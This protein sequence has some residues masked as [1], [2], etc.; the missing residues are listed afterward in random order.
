MPNNVGKQIIASGDQEYWK[1]MTDDL[2]T[3]IELLGRIRPS[4]SGQIA[5]SHPSFA[6]VFNLSSEFKKELK[7][8]V[9]RVSQLL[10][11]DKPLG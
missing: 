10:R 1:N 5:Y 9:D 11:A 6:D 3:L 4:D 7:E 2:K 8:A